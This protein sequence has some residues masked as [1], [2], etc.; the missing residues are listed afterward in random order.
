IQAF[1]NIGGVTQTIPIT[2]VTLPFISF[3]GSSLL[4]MMFSM[5]IMLSISRENTK[6]AVQERTTGV[7]VRNEVPNR[8]QTRRTNRFR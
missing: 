3:G 5:G 8:F 6:Q 1:I 2:G 7:A 4:V